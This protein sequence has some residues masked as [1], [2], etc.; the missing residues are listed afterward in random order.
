MDNLEKYIQEN[1]DQLD[2]IE[3][4]EADLIWMGIDEQ[5]SGSEKSSLDSK[6]FVLIPKTWLIGVAASIA[7]IL[8][9]GLWYIAKLSQPA[10]EVILA[11]YL[12]EFGEQ[13]KQFKALIAQ[14]EA[15]VNLANLNKSEFEEIFLELTLL[16]EIHNA[17][18]RDVPQFN[19]KNQL[20]EVLL[21]YYERK[22]RILERLSNEI[23]KRNHH[24]NQYQEKSI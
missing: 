9:A 1:R 24:E 11:D 16:E 12:P 23:E 19:Q 3:K 8:A 15:E 20:V 17:N 18:L 22:I 2:H 6:Q 7:L 13:E 5:L 10:P 4:P 14:K 21:K